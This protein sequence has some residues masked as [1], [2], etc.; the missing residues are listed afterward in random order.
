MNALALFLQYAAAFERAVVDDDW[1]R[2]KPFFDPMAV[3]RIESRLVGA[4]LV[5]SDAICAGIRRSLDGFDR[6]FD[7][8]RLE[9]IGRPE[10]FDDGC[11]IAW[12]AHYQKPGVEALTL[13]GSSLVRFRDGLL[14]EMVDTYTDEDA[15][16]AWQ[17]RNASFPVDLSYVG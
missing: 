13:C 17:A 3:Y 9:P 2:I 5:G 1:E 11:R 6:R 8:R 10:I 4:R 12:K 15:F 7:A 14:V 16:R